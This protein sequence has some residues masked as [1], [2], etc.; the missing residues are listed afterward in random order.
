[1]PDLTKENLREHI[2]RRDFAPIYVL[3]GA[4]TYLRDLAARTLASRVF[5]EADFRDFNEAEFSLLVPDS[6]R[7]AIASAEQLPMMSE[8]RVVRV[9][10]VRVAATSAKDTIKEDDE[11]ALEAYLVRPAS[12]TVL[13][14]VADELAKN[15][16]VGN[17]LR[18]HA[19]VI[20]FTPMNERELRAWAADKIREVGSE[21]DQRTID[22]LCTLV[23]NDLRRLSNEIEKLSTAVLPERLITIEKIDELVANSRE[24]SNFDLT[25]NL[26]AGRSAKAMQ[27]LRKVLDDGAEPLALL[28]LLAYNYR[29]LLIAKDLMEKGVDRSRVASA[30]KLFGKGQDEFLATA[31][32][33]DKA[34]LREIARSIAAADVAI[35]TSQGGGGKSGARMQIE[36]LAARILSLQKN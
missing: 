20:E 30:A 32:K 21:A 34:A 10:D 36:I 31:R 2:R 35:K 13:I 22:H 7:T 27:I 33:S 18:K 6:L 12:Q 1:M 11:E 29:R 23:G 9:S 14:F 15:R 19:A 24:T 4:E 26:N 28:G 5:G 16:K 17:L 8:R 25:D 3:Y